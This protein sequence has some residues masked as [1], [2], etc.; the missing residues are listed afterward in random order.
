M[1]TFSELQNEVKRRALRNQSGTEFDTAVKNA[2]NASLFRV[3][4]EAAWRVMRR[5]THFDTV[6]SYSSAS[7]S[8]TV[9]QSSTAWSITGANFFTDNIHIGCKVK[10][11]TDDGYYDIREIHAY[12]SSS[13]DRKYEGTSSTGTT[14]EILPQMEY[15]IPM[16]AGHRMFLWHEDYGYP[17]K[18]KYIPDQEFFDSSAYLT[19]KSTPTHYRMWGENMVETQ[20]LSAANITMMSSA[21]SDSKTNVTIFG[22]VSGYPCSETVALNTTS[23]TTVMSTTNKF[24][25]IERISVGSTTSGRI[26][27][28]TPTSAG[29]HV[30][31]VIPPGATSGVIRKKVQVYPLPT[32]VFP[33][34]AH[35]YKDPFPLINDEDVHEMG[36]DFDE[37]II[38]LAVAKIKYQDD[39]KEADRFMSLYRDEI[40]ILRKTNIDKI[41]W[42]PTLNRRTGSKDIFVHSNLAYRQIGADFGP[43]TRL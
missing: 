2:I 18:M 13:I 4:R 24:E 42:F 6:T 37:A 36:G 25:S 7:G 19:T 16:Q 35:Y 20:V 39:Q 8:A 41:D 31:A 38:L 11:G 14:Y 34:N 9:T 28:A 29:G 32:R 30:I 12:S 43:A 5:T 26:T 33:I 3:S 10:F 17:Y 22:D 21:V 1:L 27:I 40:R 23:G 15:T